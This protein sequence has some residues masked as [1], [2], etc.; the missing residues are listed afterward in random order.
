ME[1]A[2]LLAEPLRLAVFDDR[3]H[4]QVVVADLVPIVVFFE[5]S[6]IIGA[7][8]DLTSMRLAF[9]SFTIPTSC[10]NNKLRSGVFVKFCVLGFLASGSR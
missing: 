1:P 6:E 3:V 9:L 7:T 4:F 8:L 5:S 2:T 10:L